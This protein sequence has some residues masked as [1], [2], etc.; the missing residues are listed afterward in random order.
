MFKKVDRFKQTLLVIIKDPNKKPLS[1]ILRES[2]NFWIT[3][4]EF[5]Y[6][7]FIK[8][9][10]RKETNNYTDYLSSREVDIIT[11]SKKL[12]LQKHFLILRNKLTFA[13]VMKKNNIVTPYLIG[14]NFGHEF[15]YE[16]NCFKIQDENEL[17]SH[18]L[19]LFETTGHSKI[20]VKSMTEMGGKGVFLISKK[21]L[22]NDIERYGNYILKNDCIHQEAITQHAFIN[23]I[24][25]DSLNTMRFFTYLDKKDK[26]HIVSA[27]MRFGQ[28]GSFLDNSSSGGFYVKVN[29]ENGKLEGKS[30]QLMRYGGKR[31]AAH[32][33]TNTEFEGYSLPFFEETIVLVHKCVYTIPD[34]II[35]W[36][37]GISDKGPV[38]IEGNDNVGLMGP[39]LINKGLCRHPM[40]KEILEEA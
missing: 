6:F 20:F 3:K 36:D 32:P 40:Y 26:I 8:F 29:I 28:G 15:Y 13:E 19:K 12:H 1:T 38:V 22:Q 5:P 7:Y 10:Y 18:F 9:L 14:H 24:Y 33:D 37:I 4:K 27:Y 39:D 34:K 35:G 17:Q 11:L 31:L 2:F 23:K 16:N 30:Y 21:T 25:P